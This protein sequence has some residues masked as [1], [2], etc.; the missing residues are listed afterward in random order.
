MVAESPI[1][2]EELEKED[3]KVEVIN[4][5]TMKPLD[6]ETAMEAARKTGLGTAVG[7]RNRGLG[8]A[9]AEAIVE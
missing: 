8:S 3:I 7:K 6:N 9:V 2:P 4:M 1:P 5:H